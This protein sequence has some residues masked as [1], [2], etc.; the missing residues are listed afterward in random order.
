MKRAVLIR[1]ILYSALIAISYWIVRLHT[2]DPGDWL[3]KDT[4]LAIHK[5]VLDQ[6]GEKPLGKEFYTATWEFADKKIRE[7]EEYKHFI[8]E[9]PMPVVESSNKQYAHTLAKKLRDNIQDLL[10]LSKQGIL[11]PSQESVH[12]WLESPQNQTGVESSNE[13]RHYSLESG[14]NFWVYQYCTNSLLIESDMLYKEGKWDEAFQSLKD[15]DAIAQA[16]R[17]DSLIGHLIAETLRGKIAKGFERILLLNP[18]P[19]VDR[20]AVN[21]LNS[22]CARHIL[23]N[24]NAVMTST[25]WALFTAA[26]TPP[27]FFYEFGSNMYTL[28]LLIDNRDSLKHLEN[29][30]WI[31]R[32]LRHLRIN[33]DAL[34]R[35][36]IHTALQELNI[37][38]WTFYPSVKKFL[39]Q[40]GETE[41]E[42]AQPYSIADTFSERIPSI[43][44]ARLITYTALPN[45]YYAFIHSS[46]PAVRLELMRNAFAARLYEQDKKKF[47]DSVEELVPDYL[48]SPPVLKYVKNLFRTNGRN[49][50]PNRILSP[51]SVKRVQLDAYDIRRVLGIK[52]LGS[53]P[54]ERINIT[55]QGYL[56]WENM[57]EEEANVMADYLKH[58][59][60]VV[61]SVSLEPAEHRDKTL[62]AKINAPQ[63][64]VALYSPG[65]DCDDDGGMIAYDPTNGT[66]SSGD[67]IVYPEG[68][69]R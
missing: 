21:V 3:D 38:N 4:V 27:T 6:I 63:E 32:K 11:F 22:L 23:F 42:L 13:K 60:R 46:L 53:Y 26:K 5:Y 61:E 33:L 66:F 68:L 19:E 28:S 45:L 49:D 39:R 58:F 43:V 62:T 47:P 44:R 8:W 24:E 56:E 51:I 48:E 10:Q 17:Y 18:P 41:T 52:P 65:P 9:L 30:A 25:L 67:I 37:T 35:H 16:I 69:A 12:E 59:N 50:N 40:V 2:A 14:R 64:F 20:R 54:L 7:T 34:E 29:K 1:V 31:D 55:P 36:E 15:I 57:S